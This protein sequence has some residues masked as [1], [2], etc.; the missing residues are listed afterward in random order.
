MSEWGMRGDGRAG[1]PAD[2]LPRL[3]DPSGI[4]MLSRYFLGLLG[5]TN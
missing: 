4:L 2:S 3:H 1:D 5:K